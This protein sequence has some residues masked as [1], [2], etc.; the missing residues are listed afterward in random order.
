M[1]QSESQKMDSGSVFPAITLDLVGGGSQSLPT[2]QWTV[3]RI[4]RGNW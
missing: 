3:F 4:Y 2:A 1:A